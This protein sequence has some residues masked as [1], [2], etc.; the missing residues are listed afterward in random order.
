MVVEAE[1]SSDLTRISV[2]ELVPLKLELMSVVVPEP[3]VN[4]L[5]FLDLSALVS[6]LLEPSI[7]P[8]GS[9]TMA[10]IEVEEAVLLIPEI[11]TSTVVTT[12][13]VE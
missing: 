6:A 9:I 3:V 8:P 4:L 12:C 11:G 5:D 2:V 10:V 7:V 1:M 13:N